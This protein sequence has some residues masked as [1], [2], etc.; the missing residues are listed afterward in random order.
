MLAPW[1]VTAREGM[2]VVAQTIQRARRI[3]TI[4]IVHGSQAGSTLRG[5]YGCLSQLEDC[6]TG[7]FLYVL[8][9]VRVLLL[10]TV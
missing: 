9:T 3:C 7:T 10:I 1:L 8:Q 4:S 6:L 2:Y 5:M